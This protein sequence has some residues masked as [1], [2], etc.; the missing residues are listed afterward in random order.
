M[1]EG[2][3]GMASKKIYSS[4]LD[5]AMVPTLLFDNL[6][7]TAI[8]F[9]RDYFNKSRKTGSNSLGPFRELRT[10]AQSIKV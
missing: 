3:S 7:G 5:E 8:L 2:L 6:Q 9:N 10:G 4:E 1:S